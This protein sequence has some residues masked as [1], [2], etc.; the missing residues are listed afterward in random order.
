MQQL[1]HKTKLQFLRKEYT[2]LRERVEN[3]KK[4]LTNVKKEL[5]SSQRQEEEQKNNFVE[6]EELDNQLVKLKEELL[7][8]QKKKAF[9]RIKL[10]IILTR[11]KRQNKIYL[12][13][14]EQVKKLVEQ[15]KN[16][17]LQQKILDHLVMD[18]N[19]L[20]DKIRK[21]NL[22]HEN[23]LKELKEC[24]QKIEN[25]LRIKKNLEEKKEFELKRL[26]SISQLRK[27]STIK[28]EKKL[29][30][31]V[32]FKQDEILLFFS[33]CQR[34]LVTGTV[35][36]T[37]Q[38]VHFFP[39]LIGKKVNFSIL[40]IQSLKKVRN[41]I[42]MLDNS[43]EIKVNGLQK[44]I[45]FSGFLGKRDQC[46][47]VILSADEYC[48]WASSQTKQELMGPTSS[49]MSKGFH[50]VK[51][52]NV[53]QIASGYETTLFLFENGKIT[54]YGTSLGKNGKSYDLTNVVKIDAGHA[55]FLILTSDGSF[56]TLGKSEYYQ[57]G[58]R[59][60][61]VSKPTII[62]FFEN[63]V[64]KDFACGVLQSYVLLEN[65]DLYSF[66]Y[67]DKGSLGYDCTGNQ[68]VPKH[69]ASNVYKVFG[70]NFSYHL[71]Y[72]DGNNNLYGS[73]QNDS[74][75]LSYNGEKILVP[76]LVSEFKGIA[77]K[78]AGGLTNLILILTLEGSL[79]YSNPN[80]TSLNKSPK[81]YTYV[82]NTSNVKL[83]DF[84]TGY[85]F[86]LV[87]GENNRIFLWGE[88]TTGVFG[89]YSNINKDSLKE[90]QIPE[91]KSQIAININSGVL[92]T[93][94]YGVQGNSLNDEFKHLFE[95]MLFTDFQIGK[96]KVHKIFVE[97][98]AN[99]K[100]NIVK[101]KL[102][103]NCS[104]EQQKMFLEWVY[105]VNGN[106]NKIQDIFE[107]FQIDYKKKTLLSDLGELYKDEESKNF[108][109]LVRI[110]E[111]EDEEQDQDEDEE[112]N[113]EE[114]PVHKFILLA[115]SGL[116]REMFSNIKEE[117][118]KVKDYSEKTIESLEILVKFFY[119]DKIELTADDDP[120]LIV[121]DLKDAESYY[122]LHKNS[123]LNKQLSQIKRQ[124]GFY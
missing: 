120:E 1:D 47:D 51:L 14:D 85:N 97:K 40:S 111:D 64:V 90:I 45:T 115:R 58:F 12:D 88:Q 17:E 49:V 37:S 76:K 65:G 86:A 54:E 30:K 41:T 71:L 48:I 96:F 31:K 91:L 124:F 67:N 116:F 35:Y 39:T 11:L 38:Q 108:N 77:V 61:R 22:I 70:G 52:K 33:S 69:V 46:F 121:E 99:N 5:E 27:D 62:P 16:K 21:L 123:T 118:N 95:S 80:N 100:I 60:S 113:F 4:N 42:T 109:I 25:F 34:A 15:S 3:K 72:I 63:K 82:K 32:K 73:G 13:I 112:A 94:I 104:E 92:N 18:S 2:Q 29:K 36:I 56:Y 79:Y 93:F 8:C 81:G 102:E 20:Q 43:L 122:Q 117:S 23:N 107:K 101:E 50:Q 110:D 53:L 10:A 84:S 74:K 57:T 87:L 26:E 24:D 89:E 119:T 7:E 28:E 44:N 106:N 83:I 19:Y 98:R 55:H 6:P 103:N 78:R 105:G 114:I 66:G 9:H 59:D 75:Q 68:S